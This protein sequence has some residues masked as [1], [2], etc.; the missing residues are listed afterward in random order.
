MY[1]LNNYTIPQERVQEFKA[2]LRGE[3]TFTV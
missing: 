2:V 1:E 3:S